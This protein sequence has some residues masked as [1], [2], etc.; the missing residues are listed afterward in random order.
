M[1]CGF[2]SIIGRPNVGKSSLINSLVECHLAITSP[3][4]QT[5]RNIIQG[6][7]NDKDS[8]II[9]LDTPGI[10][11]AENRL[12]RV[13]NKQATSIIKDIDII[14]FVVDA[15]S[16]IGKGDKLIIDTL[17]SVDVP[18]ILC[19]NKIDKISNEKIIDVIKDYKD[20]YPFVEI[21]PISALRNDNIERLISVIK[22]YLPENPKENEKNSGLHSQLLGF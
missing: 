5:T 14:L 7:Y 9:F 8:Q 16:G 4:A 10:H 11:K 19:I 1:K 18:V 15:Y 3:V 12:G 2:V 13:L 17:K 21:V 20:L 22:K 6:V